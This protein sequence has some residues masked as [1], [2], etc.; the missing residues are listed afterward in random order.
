MPSSDSI[1][2]CVI[3]AAAGGSGS[4]GLEEA[5]A[6]GTTSTRSA[7]G[8]RPGRP[9]KRWPT[10]WQ[11]HW[12]GSL[13]MGEVPNCANRRRS[14]RHMVSNVR[15]ASF[16]DSSSLALVHASC[17]RAD[18]PRALRLSLLR[19]YLPAPRSCIRVWGSLI[20]TQGAARAPQLA[21]HTVGGFAAT[22]RAG[23]PLTGIPCTA[24]ASCRRRP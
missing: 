5:D 15:V 6:L 18:G 13:T 10:H 1:E 17:V 4:S 11:A 21:L 12:A 24:A 20:S 14:G 8:Q 9:P 16:W 22:Q 23:A 3:G 7:S 19:L 2:Q